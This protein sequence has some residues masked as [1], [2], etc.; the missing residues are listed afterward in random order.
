MTKSKICQVHKCTRLADFDLY[1]KSVCNQHGQEIRRLKF[2]NPQ[3]FIKWKDL[4]MG[5]NARGKRAANF[6]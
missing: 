3:T 4:R 6:E 2:L 5:R 1:D